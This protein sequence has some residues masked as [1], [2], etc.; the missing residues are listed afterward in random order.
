[1]VPTSREEAFTDV[2]KAQG[3]DIVFLIDGSTK[4]EASFPSILKF[5][6]SI[7][8]ELNIGRNADQVGVVQ[9]SDD[10]KVEFF[11]NTYSNKEDILTAV[12]RMRFMGGRALNTGKALDYVMR[13]IFTKPAGSRLDA[14]VAQML[15]LL[16]SGKSRDDVKQAGEALKRAAIVTFV[17]GGMEADGHELQEIAYS[18]NLMFAVEDFQSLPDIK[19][20]LL[21]PLKTLTV[22]IVKLP[23]TVTEG[24]KRD[25]VFLIDGTSKVGTNFYRI[26]DFIYNLIQNFDVGED[27]DRIGVVQYSDDARV[28]FP[29]NAYSNFM[30][31]LDAVRRLGL[32]GGRTLNTGS[33]LDFI[34]K[35]VLTK[36]AGSRRDLGITQILVLITTGKSQ[37]EVRLPSEILKR[38]G[39]VTFTVGINEADN[40]ELHQIAYSPKLI[41][42]VNDYWD[43]SDLDLQLLTVPNPQMGESVEIPSATTEVD[44]RDIVFLIDGSANIGKGFPIVREFLSRMIGNF[45]AGEEKVR[46]GVTQFSENPRTEF[47]LN[48]YSTKNEMLSAVKKLKLKRGKKLNIG[49]ALDHVMKNAFAASAGSRLKSSVPQI[50]L[51][52]TSEKS[53]DDISQQAAKLREMGIV[54]FTVGVKKANQAQLEQIAYAPKLAFSLSSIRGLFDI[55]HQ[56]QTIMKSVVVEVVE[57]PLK[58]QSH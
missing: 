51:L 49:A 56:L 58:D 42:Q 36:S 24:N 34:M 14:G 10:P 15:V 4:V 32:K 7:T 43:L 27:K 44:K 50:L 37:D 31:L 2:M 57:I 23:T 21:R 47:L 30:T 33:A 17:I 3:R 26:R 53:R 19:N 48:T 18:S 5:L 12:Q 35:N 45:D 22:E 55:E 40:S 1:M 29:L 41:F 46:F 20:Q 16:T 11:M 9:Y 39:V 54:T 28:E 6:Q 52:L 13:H 25:V 8:Q 38:A